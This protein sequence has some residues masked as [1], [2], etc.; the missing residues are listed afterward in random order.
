MKTKGIIRKI[1]YALVFIA[2]IASFIYL[3]NKYAGNSEIKVLDITDFYKD[4]KKE[5]FEVIKGGK[6]ISLLKKGKHIIV[7][8]NSKSK[9]SQKYIQEINSIVEELE[10]QDIYYYDII[11]DKAQAN[12]NYYELI[13]LLDGYLITTDISENNLLAPS[14]YIIDKGKVKYY[15]IETSAMKNTDKVNDYWTEEKEIEF[16]TEIS[17]AIHK[18]YLNKQEK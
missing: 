6:F 9:Y 8:G 13:E 17:D 11:N 1:I 3:G 15:N 7:I 5:N 2:M 12:S 4:I 16:K 18:Y 14:L 10:L